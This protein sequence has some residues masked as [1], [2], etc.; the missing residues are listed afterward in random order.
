MLATKQQCIGFH[1]QAR[2]TLP[3]H[4]CCHCYCTVSKQAWNN[5]PSHMPGI[6]YHR[7]SRKNT[8]QQEIVERPWRK[9]NQAPRYVHSLSS[10]LSKL[11]TA[12]KVHFPQDRVDCWNNEN[13]GKNDRFLGRSLSLYFLFVPLFRLSFE[14]KRVNRRSV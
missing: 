3:C 8:G 2:Q 1:K 5:D 4:H 7:V 14:N 11:K 12:T 6:P 13:P 10:K 9:P